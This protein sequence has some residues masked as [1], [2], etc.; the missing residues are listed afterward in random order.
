MTKISF[1]TKDL[2]HG[3][4]LAKIIKPE[5]NDF[6]IKF[7]SKGMEIFSYNKRRY[8]LVKVLHDRTNDINDT[9]SSDE[10]Y[11]SNDRVAL[12]GSE[13]TTS[14]ISVNDSSLSIKMSGDDGQTRKTTIKKRSG[15]SMRSSIPEIDA[16]PSVLLN[17][18]EFDLLL[19]QVS[20]S[21]LKGESEEDLRLNQVHFYPERNCA[22]SSTGY[23]GTVVYLNGMQ[24]DLSIVG[25]DVPFIRSF[26][27]KCKGDT[28]GL[29][30]N[31]RGLFIVD[32]IS[33]SYLFMSKILVKK[34]QL[35]I[36]DEDKFETEVFFD[37]DILRKNLEWAELAIEGTQ[38]LTFKIGR[39]LSDK[40]QVEF[41]NAGHEIS[42]FEG[43]LL[44]GDKLEG[45]F[46]VRFL[47]LIVRYIDGNVVLKFNHFKYPNIMSVSQ[48][49]NNGPIQYVHYLASMKSR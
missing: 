36:L 7:D 32:P 8:V 27:S 3:F 35:H 39:V 47:N 43:K 42:K 4:G 10:Y 26:C 44:K 5:I 45:D 31:D 17:R 49:E 48:Y 46:P 11:I 18:N 12:F 38:R 24:L 23:H 30:Q 19:R 16:S 21:V 22:T 13:L 29:K 1:N 28:I 34:P 2:K 14:L 33:N 40:C 37:K 6:C 9:Y 41:Y 25:P 15:K 20:C